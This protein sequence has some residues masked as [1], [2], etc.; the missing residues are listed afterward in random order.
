MNIERNNLNSN[1]EPWL[2]VVLSAFWAGMGQIYAQRLLRGYIFIFGAFIS[3]FLGLWLIWIPQ[4]NLFLAVA[5][6]IF[7]VI[8][9]IYS[10]FD[11]YKCAK[12]RN[13]EEFERLRKAS[14]D[15]WLAVF[16]SLILPGIGHMYLKKWL[17][18]IGL[19]LCWIPLAII[20]GL[21][22]P[23]DVI[24]TAILWAFAC[25]HVYISSPARRERSLKSIIMVVIA[26]FVFNGTVITNIMRWKI[27]P[28]K[29]PSHSMAPTIQAGDRILV[30]K[31][32]GYIP[33]RG[34]LILFRHPENR[35]L[36]YLK[37]AIAFGGESVEIKEGM[38]YIDGNKLESSPYRNFNYVSVGSFGV[39]GKPFKVPDH[40][41][42]VLGD[43]SSNSKDSRFWGAVPE[44]DVIGKAF[45]RYWPP[46]RIGPIES[47]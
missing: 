19:I 9:R 11:A 21:S 2:A 43:D 37:R 5:F 7:A 18:G 40:A 34:D 14:K 35:E 27:Q 13:S 41:V 44:S 28:F 45:K 47:F 36:K 6:L 32:S 20:S 12:K 29:F 1:K 30:K 38:I 23:L 24:L 33:E 39:K 4:G 46:K 10:L 15:P 22:G 42:F 17:W 25:G 16:L 8:I 26:V 3:L 31:P